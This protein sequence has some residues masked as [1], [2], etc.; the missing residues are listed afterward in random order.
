MVYTHA[1]LYETMRIYPLVPSDAKEAA[2][3]GDLPDG[4]VVKEGTRISYH[5]YVIGRVNEL[6]GSNWSTSSQNGGC[7]LIRIIGNQ[8]LWQETLIHTLCFK[9]GRE[10]V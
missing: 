1:G 10:Y 5:P 4:T 9:R 7:R 3:D 6:W 2:S 8:A